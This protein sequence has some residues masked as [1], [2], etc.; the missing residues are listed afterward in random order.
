L[1]ATIHQRAHVWL[2]DNAQDELLQAAAV[3][4]DDGYDGFVRKVCAQPSAG[5]AGFSAVKVKLLDGEEKKNQGV[6]AGLL[7]A[8]DRL[9][10]EGVRL[11]V[12]GWA[13][14]RTNPVRE[15]ELADEV[16]RDEGASFWDACGE[17]E[18]KWGG[19]S[20]L[21]EFNRS[22]LYARRLRQLRPRMVLGFVS[23][24][25]EAAGGYIDWSAWRVADARWMPE[26]YANENPGTPAIWPDEAMV[27][28]ENPSGARFFHAYVHP[29]LGMH[30]AALRVD[31]A[32]YI[33]HLRAAKRRGFTYGFSVYSAHYLAATDWAAFST[34]IKSA[35]DPTALAWYA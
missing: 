19:G 24:P 32:T 18:Y 29:V 33:F 5:G 34:V 13:Q 9:A 10:Q 22:G 35:P 21:T 20:D 8:R 31:A 12:G 16:I 2:L 28:N 11:V 27:A 1:T 23:M 26:C 30:D 15:A 3:L 14:L 4:G 17:A 6:I 25:N 7:A